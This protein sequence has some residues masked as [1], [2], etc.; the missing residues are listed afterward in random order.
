MRYR[1]QVHELNVPLRPG[2][3][4]V[5]ESDVEEADVRFDELYEQAYGPGSG[6]REA[7]K[8]IMVFRVVA[9][10]ELKKPNLRSYQVSSKNP[11]RGLKGERQVY[12]EE[13]K[14]FV[15]T[16]I[17]DFDRLVPGSEVVGPAIIETPVTTMVINPR[18]RAAVD[19]FLN[20]RIY[21]Q[22]S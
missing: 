6:Y 20:V 3:A 11:D 8:E 7:G 12:F 21:L 5:S 9:T 18:D 15:A 17:Y 22:D 2:V 4:E 13:H 10:G 14:D 19:E 16:K 1:N